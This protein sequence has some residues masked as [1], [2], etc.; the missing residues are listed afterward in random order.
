MK[1]LKQQSVE[2]N[3]AGGR[4]RLSK[5]NE[6]TPGRV[7]NGKRGFD[8]AAGMGMQSKACDLQFNIKK[9]TGVA[10]TL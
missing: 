4:S 7:G 1:G 10:Q 3:E 2:L 5:D 9:G 6:K 8:Q